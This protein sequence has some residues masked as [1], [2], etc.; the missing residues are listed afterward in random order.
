MRIKETFSNR[1]FRFEVETFLRCR[2]YGC[3][4]DGD[5]D[6]NDCD[7]IDCYFKTGSIK[8]TGTFPPE[9][10]HFNCRQVKIFSINGTIDFSKYCIRNLTARSTGTITDLGSV[11]CYDGD[12]KSIIGDLVDMINQSQVQT[13]TILEL[14]K[15]GFTK[16]QSL[17]IH[18]SIIMEELKIPRLS[19]VRCTVDLTKL[20]SDVKHLNLND[21]DCIGSIEVKNIGDLNINRSRLLPQTLI[22]ERVSIFNMQGFHVYADLVCTDNPDKNFINARR[23]DHL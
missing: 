11:E 10:C 17:K 9:C 19:F 8:F 1:L 18:K 4:F 7:F 22:A 20:R 2:F 5:F 15:F 14:K 21:C 6:F 16:L 13:L 12:G 3:R 23:I